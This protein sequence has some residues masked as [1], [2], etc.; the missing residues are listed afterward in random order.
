MKGQVDPMQGCW[1][2]R[3]DVTDRQLID[4]TKGWDERTWVSGGV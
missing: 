2:L 3:I 1:R 4:R